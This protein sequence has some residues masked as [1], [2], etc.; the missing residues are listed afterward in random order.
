MAREL[1]VIPRK[2]LFEQLGVSSA[3]ETW[4]TRR[5]HPR[6]RRLPLRGGRDDDYPLESVTGVTGNY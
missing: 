2:R 3:K 6:F 4:T 1:N 5:A